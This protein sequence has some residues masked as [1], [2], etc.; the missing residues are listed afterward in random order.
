MKGKSLEDI[1]KKKIELLYK[2]KHDIKYKISTG[3]I[4]S[5][6]MENFEEFQEKINKLKNKHKDYDIN[7]YIKVM[8][9]YFQSFKEEMENNE[10]KKIEEDRI[11]KY[12]RQYHEDYNTK[13]FYKDIQDK[14]LCKVVNYSQINHINSL[15]QSQDI[16]I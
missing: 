3:G 8:E 13:I 10:L 12:L 2:F 4:S 1:E 11:N 14:I 16:A 9:Q 6:G 15:N 5:N 7:D